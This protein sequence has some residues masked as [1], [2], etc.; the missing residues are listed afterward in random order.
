MVQVADFHTHIL[1]QVDDGS[2]SL[3][4]TLAMLRME[5]EQG[6]RRVVATPHFYAQTDKP[7]RFLARRAAA[8]EKVAEALHREPGLPEVTLGA[9]VHYF[10]G[11]SE[12]EILPELTIGKTPYILIEMPTSAWG[13]YMFRELEDIWSQRGIVP[14]IAHIDRYVGPWRNSGLPDRLA[15]LP[16]LVQA[17]AD[18]FLRRLTAPMAMRLFEAGKIHL[19]GS[20][21]HNLSYRKPNL[22][23]AVALIEKRLGQKVFAQL[24]DCQNRIL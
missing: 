11:I 22:A 16:V 9:E 1:P 8:M 13:E 19:L 23:A 6:I 20:D 15:E 10:R 5:A 24:Q 18:F 3:E 4:E 7:E 12:T 17:N 2:H 21:C 14:I